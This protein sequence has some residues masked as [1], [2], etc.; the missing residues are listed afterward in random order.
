MGWMTGV[1]ERSFNDGFKILASVT[2]RLEMPL[3]SGADW[4]GRVLAGLGHAKSGVPGQRLRS[5]G[6]EKQKAR[7]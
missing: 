4:E 6:E 1:R 7:P 2:G 5:V 3:L